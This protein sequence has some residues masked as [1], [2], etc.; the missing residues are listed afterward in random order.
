MDR[1][2]LLAAIA[3]LAAHG[4]TDEAAVAEQLVARGFTIDEAWRL[5]LFV[6][7]AF[8]RPVLEELG[9][10]I[11]PDHL[12]VPTEEGGELRAYLA[13]QPEYTAALALARTHRAAGSAMPHEHYVAVAG[14]AAE[15]DATSNALNAGADV[16]GAAIATAVVD[17][18]FVKY[19][20]LRAAG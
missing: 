11:F 3:L 13:D 7:M 15:I 2:R 16:A 8:S 6:P 12:V 14:A 1:E 18:A 17:P 20:K 9:V 5:I 4:P 10:A 19:V